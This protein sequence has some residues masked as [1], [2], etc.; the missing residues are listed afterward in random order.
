MFLETVAKVGGWGAYSGIGGM[1]VKNIRGEGGLLGNRDNERKAQ[2]ALRGTTPLNLCSLHKEHQGCAIRP[3]R[4]LF[5]FFF[6]ISFSFH[7]VKQIQH[8]W[9]KKK[10]NKISDIFSLPLSATADNVGAFCARR[11]ASWVIFSGGSL[12]TSVRP[13]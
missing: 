12:V 3:P 10:Q 9:N 1:N 2:W 7:T 13:H 5:S 4:H 6:Y 8:K 11:F